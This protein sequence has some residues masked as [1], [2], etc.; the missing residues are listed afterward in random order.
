MNN[1]IFNKQHVRQ[2]ICSCAN[3]HHVRPAGA[4]QDGYNTE[5]ALGLLMNNRFTRVDD[6]LVDTLE[7]A[8]KQLIDEHVRQHKQSGRTVR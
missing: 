7:L 8:C 2:W 5:R 1:S 4:N 6:E 3:Q